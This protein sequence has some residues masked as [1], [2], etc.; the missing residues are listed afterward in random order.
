MLLWR[1][2]TLCVHLF[3]MVSKLLVFIMSLFIEPFSDCFYA[4][5]FYLMYCNYGI[6]FFVKT[7]GEG[8]S[9]ELSLRFFLFLLHGL[10]GVF[11]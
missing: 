7:G 2:C 8:G 1:S 11:R 3:H 5:I 6:R 4:L 9:D 10:Y